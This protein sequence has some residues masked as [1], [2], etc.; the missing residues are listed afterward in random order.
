MV[1]Q[2]PLFPGLPGGP[3]L[4]VI[5]LVMVLILGIPTVIVGAA[6]IFGF[7]YV[8]GGDGRAERIEELEREVRDL[9]ATLEREQGGGDAD[10]F[11]DADA[12]DGFDA[13]RR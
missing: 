2:F 5:L 1:L 3:E 10:S 6:A 4:L 12:D 9:R 7:K 11:P 8:R 13:G